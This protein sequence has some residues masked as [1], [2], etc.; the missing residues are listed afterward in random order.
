MDNLTFDWWVGFGMKS[1]WGG[2]YGGGSISQ[3][4][5]VGDLSDLY[6]SYAVTNAGFPIVEFPA[7]LSKSI[8]RL[9]NVLNRVGPPCYFL[10]WVMQW[11]NGHRQAMCSIAYSGQEATH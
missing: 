4:T 11:S 7:I 3:I 2:N 10:L 1:L 6:P 5:R 9:T 8:T